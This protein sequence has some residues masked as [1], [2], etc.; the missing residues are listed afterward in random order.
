MLIKTVYLI[1]PP[2]RSS[3]IYHIYFNQFKL[4]PIIKLIYCVRVTIIPGYSPTNL[5]TPFQSLTE[6]ITMGNL[7]NR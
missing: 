7:G 1:Y 4:L 5:Y 2:P 6:R 3:H